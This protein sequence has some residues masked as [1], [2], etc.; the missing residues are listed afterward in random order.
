[1]L[2]DDAK[3][4]DRLVRESPDEAYEESFMVKMRAQAGWGLS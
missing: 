4:L 1:L 2:G 3:V